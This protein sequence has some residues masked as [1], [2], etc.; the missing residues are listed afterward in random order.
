VPTLF[1][2]RANRFFIILAVGAGLYSL[3]FHWNKLTGEERVRDWCVTVASR[4]QP[5]EKSVAEY[6]KCWA[7]WMA[8]G[9]P[10]AIW[11]QRRDAVV[12]GVISGLL[13]YLFGMLL[14][15]CARWVWNG[16]RGST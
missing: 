12:Y 5:L 9:G 13:I 4:Q 8:D 15:Y 6:N 14:A 16:T 7:E 11:G 3:V 1:I 10:A 2:E